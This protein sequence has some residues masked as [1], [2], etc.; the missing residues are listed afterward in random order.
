MVKYVL[1]P[2]FLLFSNFIKLVLFF[3]GYFSILIKMRGIFIDIK[4]IEILHGVDYRTACRRMRTIRDALEK[5][6]HQ[7]VT[8]E[9]YCKFEGITRKQFNEGTRITPRHRQAG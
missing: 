9:E 4:D 8:I 1:N 5:K 2:V 7:R 3:H 6:K